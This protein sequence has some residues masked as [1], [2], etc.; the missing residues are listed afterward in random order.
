M[1]RPI[2]FA[3]AIAVTTAGLAL[4]LLVLR[5]LVPQFFVFFFNSNL[6]DFFWSDMAMICCQK[7]PFKCENSMSVQIS[8]HSKITN[9]VKRVLRHLKSTRQSLSSILS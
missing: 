7:L 4:C 2:A 6:H 8:K 3:S 9:Y 1:I 5:M